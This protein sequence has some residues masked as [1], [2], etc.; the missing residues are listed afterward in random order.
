[1]SHEVTNSVLAL[2]NELTLAYD[3]A[4]REFPERV[5]EIDAVFSVVDNLRS[6]IIQIDGIAL[7]PTPHGPLSI[8]E[9][10]ELHSNL[11][12]DIE[13]LDSISR[14]SKSLF[15][16]RDTPILWRG[17]LASN[18]VEAIRD[19]ALHYSW[20]LQ[21]ESLHNTL[22]SSPANRERNPEPWFSISG[23]QDVASK[24]AKRIP[25]EAT[26]PDVTSTDQNGTIKASQLD[27]DRVE[28]LNQMKV[29]RRTTQKEAATKWAKLYNDECDEQGIRN[30]VYR[31]KNHGKLKGKHNKT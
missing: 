26:V 24:I 11:C 25:V 28:F 31:V 9:I 8:D 10:D 12:H 23:V 6:C 1:M 5:S 7:K 20:I 19:E 13:S 16:W 18:V 15:T 3:K 2:W 17:K 29:K 4:V 21:N 22:A 30:A 27:R 14:H